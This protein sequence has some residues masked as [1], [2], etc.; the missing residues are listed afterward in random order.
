MA[1]YMLEP[2]MQSRTCPNRE[3]NYPHCL[4]CC[5][6]HPGCRVLTPTL[7]EWTCHLLRGT[8]K[9]IHVQ[10]ERPT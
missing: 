8:A 9:L 5:H 10:K 3:E 7:V 4:V 6:G 1:H 2:P